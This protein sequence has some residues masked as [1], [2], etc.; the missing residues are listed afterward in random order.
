MKD[1]ERTPVYEV[2]VATIEEFLRLLDERE[3]SAVSRDSGECVRRGVFIAR[4]SEKRTSRFGFPSVR[5]YVVASFVYGRDLVSYRV[6]T[7]SIVELPELVK[8]MEERQ[9]S[10]YEQVRGDISRSLA[11]RFPDVSI[12]EGNLRLLHIPERET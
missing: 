8:S 2:E 3:S 4:I 11:E 7:S 12:Y 6:A 10:A 9:Q 1:D 5:R